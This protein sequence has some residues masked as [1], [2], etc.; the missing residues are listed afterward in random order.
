M[1]TFEAVYRQEFDYVARSLRRLG[2]E[3]QDIKDLCQEVFLAVHQKL[4]VWDSSRPLRPWLFGFAFRAVSDWR[5][6]AHRRREVM[7]VEVTGV[8]GRADPGSDAEASE[9]RRLVLA[10]LETLS[11]ERRAAFILHDLDG[12]SAPDIAEALEVPLN[13]VYSRLRLARADVTSTL[14]A[15]LAEGG[16]R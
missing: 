10:A 3:P 12:A 4:H 6:R 13:T 1:V 14:R 5:G 7:G 16:A 8:P 2:A 11:P 9:A 15:R